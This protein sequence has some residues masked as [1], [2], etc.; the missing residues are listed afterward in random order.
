M[1]DESI[2]GLLE[3]H[4]FLLKI[5]EEPYMV[6]E[7]PFLNVDVDYPTKCSK[8]VHKKRSGRIIEDISL[9]IQAESPHVETMKEI[10]TRKPEPQVASPVKNDSSFQKLDEEIPDAV[11][12]YSPEVSGKAFKNVPDSPKDKDI[13]GRRPSLL[14]S[15]FPNIIPEQKLP[16]F[17]V[18]NGTNSDLIARGSP[19]RNFQFSVEQRPLEIIPKAAPPESSLGFSFSVPPPVSHAVFKDDPLIIH[20]EH[21]DEINEFSENCQDEEI[22]EAKL[23]LFLR[24]LCLFISEFY[25]FTYI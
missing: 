16:R 23:K 25:I 24:F 17:G 4:G 5:F 2:E 9:S 12:S 1:E 6:K 22:A 7:G 18:F 10:Q 21:E 15:P 14:S 13:S 19:N 3:Y 8:L 20:Q 11:A